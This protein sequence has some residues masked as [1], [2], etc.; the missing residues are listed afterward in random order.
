M[1]SSFL[2]PFKYLVLMSLAFVYNVLSARDDIIPSNP[3]PQI[4][5]KVSARM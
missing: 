4:L 1:D 2:I 3:K 5:T